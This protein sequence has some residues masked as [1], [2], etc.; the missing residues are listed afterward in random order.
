MFERLEQIAERYE[1]LGRQL[2][3]DEIV[4]DHLAYQKLR[5]SIATWNR[6]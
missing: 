2:G 1:D 5:N 6:W 4:N 3:S